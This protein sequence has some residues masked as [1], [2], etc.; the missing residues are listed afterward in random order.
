MQI[1]HL[2]AIRLLHSI[3]HLRWM[4]NEIIVGIAAQRFSG[5]LFKDKLQLKAKGPF[6]RSDSLFRKLDAS[7]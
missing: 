3:V 6:T 2:F 7:V 4:T 5:R 1:I